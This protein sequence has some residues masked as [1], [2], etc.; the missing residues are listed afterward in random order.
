MKANFFCQNYIITIECCFF[1]FLLK[2][3][4]MKEVRAD[5]NQKYRTITGTHNIFSKVTLYEKLHVSDFKYGLDPS[6][7]SLL[8]KV[9]KKNYEKLPIV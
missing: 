3:M 1:V 9:P 5:L 6:D 8:K 4:K 2:T 7:W